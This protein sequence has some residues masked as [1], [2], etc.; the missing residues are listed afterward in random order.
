MSHR[1]PDPRQGDLEVSLRR[2]L[3]AAAESVEP[4]ADGLDRIRA[5]VSA[6][7]HRMPQRWS[8][9]A[10]V[11]ADRMPLRQLAM[12]A[13][14]L[15]PIL[16]LVVDRFRP[17]PGGGGR[18]GWLRPAAAVA[19]GLFVVV[20]GSWAVTDLP[21]VIAPTANS[22]SGP[23]TIGLG[24]RTPTRSASPTG[25]GG[26]GPGQGGH[27][28]PAGSPSC[29]SRGA[30]SHAPTATPTTTASPTVTATPSVSSSPTITPSVSS[31]PTISP[32][33]SSSPTDSTSTQAS[34]Q[35][36][37][38]V[39]DPDPNTTATGLGDSGASGDPS[40]PRS[41]SKTG[42]N[43]VLSPMLTVSPV[44]TT[45]PSPAPTSSPLPCV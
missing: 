1:R 4:R 6:G 13:A 20:A 14:A 10:L 41:N 32:S 34:P 8:P 24:T 5:K 12:A 22:G 27:S 39:A 16:D 18:Y 40:G 9:A 35:S 38:Q 3:I 37:P 17:N 7:R 28:R 44:P 25:R 29:S 31:S 36:T 19:T 45:S 21:Q 42:G 30:A 2:A 11:R 23:P 26:V 33:V 43:H 15:R